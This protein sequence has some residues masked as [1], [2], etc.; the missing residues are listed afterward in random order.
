MPAHSRFTQ[1]AIW[2]A[3][4]RFDNEDYIMGTRCIT[5]IR[6][7]WGTDGD[8]STNATIYRHWDGYLEGHGRWLHDFLKDLHVVNGIDSNM[9]E[10]YAN[11]P[12]R[13]AAMLVSELQADG[14][15]PDLVPHGSIM[16]QEYHYQIDV[17]FGD[18][19]A[20]AI[21]VFD[22]PMTAWH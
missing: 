15:D 20:V 9:P 16:G 13:L 12:G 22:G 21:T 19:G 18:S 7:R 3:L 2:D 17:T 11:G 5:V 6:S 14:H 8:W 10:R 4:G 1:A